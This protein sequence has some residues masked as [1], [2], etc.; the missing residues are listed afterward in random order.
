MIWVLD[1]YW[2]RICRKK[3]LRKD[4]CFVKQI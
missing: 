1:R 4:D 2:R 3:V